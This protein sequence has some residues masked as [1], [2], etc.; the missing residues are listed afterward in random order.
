MNAEINL[1]TF[2]TAL[3]LEQFAHNV[4]LRHHFRHQEL[5]IDAHIV[6]SDLAPW[7]FDSRRV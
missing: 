4:P 3:F 5:Q 7:L 2:P 6:E 1:L